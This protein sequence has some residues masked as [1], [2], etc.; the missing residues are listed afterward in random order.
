MGIYLG[1]NQIDTINLIQYPNIN[2]DLEDA[3]IEGTISNYTNSEC[4]FIRTTA[5]EEHDNLISISFP[6]CTYIDDYGIAGCDNLT[7]ISFPKCKYIGKGAFGYCSSL[8][9][10]N[11]LNCSII[12]EGAFGDCSS[13]IEVDFPVCTTIG[14][15]AFQYCGALTSINFPMCTTIEGNAFDGCEALVEANLPN[16]TTINEYA[17]SACY[18]L[19]SVSLPKCTFVGS[20]AFYS[21]TSLKQIK[22]MK[23]S[24]IMTET[25]ADCSQLSTALFM[26]CNTV[27]DDAFKNCFALTTIELPYCTTVGTSAFMNCSTLSQ[28]SLSYCSTIGYRAFEN[29]TSLTIISLPRC[30]YIYDYAFQSCYKLL[31]LNLLGQSVVTLSGVSVFGSTPISDYTALTNGV[32]GSIYVPYSLYSQYIV[33]QNWSYYSS[34]I[35]GVEGFTL[36]YQTS[37]TSQI[38]QYY[39]TC[40]FDESIVTW[41]DWVNSKYNTAELT[42]NDNHVVGKWDEDSQEY[43]ALQDSS[44][45]QSITDDI[46]IMNSSHIVIIPMKPFLGYLPIKLQYSN[47]YIPFIYETSMTWI[48]W[49]NSN[50][51]LLE[52]TVDDNLNIRIWDDATNMYKYLTFDEESQN[53]VIANHKIIEDGINIFNQVYLDIELERP[54][55]Y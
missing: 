38:Y 6:K 52:L 21:C 17:F 23:C 19:T 33:A 31:S 37:Q 39:E 10:A 32:Y 25:F 4:S 36:F 49:I 44:S 20:G 14:Y 46:E 28:V 41:A 11:F 7:M 18:S 34:R 13:L 24:S 1:S 55:S 8:I 3:F 54:E 9:E 2:N 26:T 12:N 27:E 40:I 48:E 30:N 47:S 42:I 22:L 51:N 45:G 15:G 53:K 5:F 29:C 16:C 50:Y 43:C 35:V